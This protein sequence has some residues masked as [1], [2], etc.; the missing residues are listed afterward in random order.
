MALSAKRPVCNEKPQNHG[1]LTPS[2]DNEGSVVEGN[3]TPASELSISGNPSNLPHVVL[4]STWFGDGKNH[5]TR[6]AAQNH[7][8]LQS[9]GGQETCSSECSHKLL[10]E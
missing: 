8:L 4:N 3:L 9:F 5:L 10:R 7:M 1:N 6:L 2:A